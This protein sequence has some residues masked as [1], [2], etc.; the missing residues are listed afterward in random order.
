MPFFLRTEF[1]PK[2]MSVKICIVG[3]PLAGK[4]ALFGA[5]TGASLDAASARGADP[6]A[7]V[8]VPDERLEK[9]AAVFEPKKKTAAAIEFQELA[10]IAAAEPRKADFSESFLAKLRTADALLAVVR[11]SSRSV[12]MSSVARATGIPWSAR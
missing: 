12:V 3:P 7:V 2:E 6:V 4:S 9:L 10:A 1:S 8:K 11:A 5:L